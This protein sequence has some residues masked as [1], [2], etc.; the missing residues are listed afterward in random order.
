MPGSYIDPTA[1]WLIKIG[2]HSGLSQDAVLLTHDDSLSIQTGFTRIAPVEIGERVFVGAGA[3]ILPGSRLGDDSMV[4]A[5][6]VVSGDVPAGSMVA[7]H[8]A[9]VMATVQRA[10]AWHRQTVSNA[11]LWPKDGWTTGMGITD[12]RKTAQREALASTREG[13]VKRPR[14]WAGR[15]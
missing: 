9:R 1:P 6:T 8:P 14:P 7:G 10:E 15:G 5:G 4:A 2:S 11:P 13:Y 12:E 3:I